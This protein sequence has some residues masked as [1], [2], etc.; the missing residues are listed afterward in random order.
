[1]SNAINSGKAL[2]KFRELIK[3]QGGN[4]QCIE[5]Y[6][7]FPISKYIVPIKAEKEGFV[8]KIKTYEIAVGCKNI[9]GGREKKTDSIDLSAVIVLKKKVG[10]YVNIGDTLFEIYSNDENKIKENIELFNSV[11]TIE[12]MPPKPIPLIYKVIE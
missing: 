7:M 12:E 4:P 11:F 2:D 6:S 5:D 1:M 10:D 3:C 8:N 9:G